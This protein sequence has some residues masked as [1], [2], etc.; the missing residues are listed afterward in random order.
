MESILYN[1]FAQIFTVARVAADRRGKAVDG[2]TQ[3]HD[4]AAER[5]KI[6]HPKQCQNLAICFQ[7]HLSDFLA[8]VTMPSQCLVEQLQ[9]L[10]V[11]RVPMLIQRFVNDTVQYA[12]LLVHSRQ[13]NEEMTFTW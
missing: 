2:G 7:C 8:I 9:F 4:Y 10:K 13:K 12:A 3:C 6:S 1:S 11:A 5:D